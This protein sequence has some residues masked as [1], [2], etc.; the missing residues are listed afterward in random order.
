MLLKEVESAETLIYSSDNWLK[1]RKPDDWIEKTV[2]KSNPWSSALTSDVLQTY[3]L[4]NF[5]NDFWDLSRTF[6]AR[7]QTFGTWNS[8][9]A[10]PEKN[11][12]D[13]V[14]LIYGNVNFARTI[15][16]SSLYITCYLH[17]CSKMLISSTNIYITTWCLQILA[18]GVDHLIT[19]NQHA[20][21]RTV[22]SAVETTV[23]MSIVS[24]PS[25]TRQRSWK[26]KHQRSQILELL[27]LE[28]L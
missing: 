15:S 12:Y 4:S 22:S 16:W 10:R 11:I 1:S 6:K 2:V 21:V 14:W 13:Y 19:R 25:I 5:W 26:L 7:P 8:K 17:V 28:I 23:H 20:P 9:N 3:H 27:T 18:P 24:L